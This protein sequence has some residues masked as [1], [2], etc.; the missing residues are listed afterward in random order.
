MEIIDKTISTAHQMYLGA[1]KEFDRMFK[2]INKLRKEI[3]EEP[4]SRE[5]MYM[6]AR[7]NSNFSSM[8]TIY[9]LIKSAHN[10]KLINRESYLKYLA[11]YTEII[12]QD[13]QGSKIQHNRVIGEIFLDLR[14]LKKKVGGL[15]LLKNIN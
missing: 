9:W 6:G 14:A 3:Q 7:L 2:L 4:S 15:P 1:T 13:T 12:E 8:Y 10:E 11:G 5:K